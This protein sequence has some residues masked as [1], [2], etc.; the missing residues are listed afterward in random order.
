MTKFRNTFLGLIDRAAD[1][2]KQIVD[3]LD[4]AVSDIDLDEIHKDFGSR[5]N[6]ILSSGRDFFSK[7]DETARFMRDT[8]KPFVVTLSFDEAKGEEYTYNINGRVIKIEVTFNSENE[9]SGRSKRVVVPEGYDMSQATFEVNNEKKL[10]IVSVPLI[11]DEEEEEVPT[12]SHEV[13]EA[14]NPTEET[15]AQ[16]QSSTAN[17]TLE[18]TVAAN[19]R[20]ATAARMR[21]NSN[22]QFCGKMDD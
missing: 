3:S 16:P 15:V 20:K 19:V 21:R 13:A 11:N 14:E 5:F 18:E 7:I 10:L 12:P 17:D 22:G 1:S 9:M 2:S 8:T 6:S 4:K